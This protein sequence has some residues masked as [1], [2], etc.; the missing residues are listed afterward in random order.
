M[1]ISIA[2]KNVTLLPQEGQ[3]VGGFDV[4]IAVGTDGGAMSKVSKAAQPIK[5]PLNA[6]N[7][8]RSKP[9]TYDVSIVVRPGESTLSVG[10]VD[11]IS[12]ASG[13]A[14]TKIVAR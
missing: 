11:E 1:H 13:F 10:I 6:E 7:T 2:S 4:Y 5:I 12:S 14:R 3:L 8:L 9:M